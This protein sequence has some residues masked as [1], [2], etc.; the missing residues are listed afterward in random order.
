[1]KWKHFRH[2]YKEK[3]IIHVEAPIENWLETLLNNLQAETFHVLEH[4]DEFIEVLI[5]FPPE[6]DEYDENGKLHE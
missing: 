6:R 3:R 1:M 2:F 4:T 5:K